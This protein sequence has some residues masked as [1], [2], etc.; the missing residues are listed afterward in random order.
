LKRQHRFFVCSRLQLDIAANFQPDFQENKQTTTTT[1]TTTKKNNNI[2]AAF[3][4]K[5]A[6]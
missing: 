1:T 5:T 2:N 3:H 4:F 6:D